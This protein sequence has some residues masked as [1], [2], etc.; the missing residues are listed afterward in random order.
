MNNQIIKNCERA[1]YLM[2]L[3]SYFS[4]L[5][6]LPGVSFAYT[7]LVT[8][9]WYNQAY[10]IHS[11]SRKDTIEEKKDILDKSNLFF[12]KHD[13]Q[14]CF[15]LTPATAF[16][17]FSQFLLDNDLVVFDEEAWMFYDFTNDLPQISKGKI[18]VRE[19]TEKDLDLFGEV[20]CRV[21]PGP[22]VK[23]YVQCVKNGFLSHPPLVDIKYYL[24]FY[25]ETPVGMLSLLSIGNC[26]GLYA[27]AVDEDYQHK[28]VCRAL[29]SKAI[30]ECKQKQIEYLFLQTGNGEES[31]EAFEHLGFTTQ[32]VRKGY[33]LKAMAEDV[34]HG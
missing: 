33:I 23:E 4:E 27:V 28:G 9:T 6:D 17:N 31:Q 12:D 18:E 13:R 20:Y 22:E 30:V 5:T 8:D 11:V 7:N 19:I 32:F 21:L 26:A 2:Q 10:N 3:S 34:Q 24:A 15:Y 29:V 1:H 25:E 14:V 16:E